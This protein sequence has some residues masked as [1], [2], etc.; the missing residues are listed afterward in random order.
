M[1]TWEELKDVIRQ[2]MD[3][4]NMEDITPDKRLIEDLGYDSLQV[5]DLFAEIESQFG[6]DF[7]DLEDFVERFNLCRTLWEGI[8]ELQEKDRK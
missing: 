2:C 8:C 6:V 3:E 7:T 4:G 1:T 5:M